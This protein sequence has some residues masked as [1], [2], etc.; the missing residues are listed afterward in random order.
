MNLHEA[1]LKASLVRFLGRKQMPRRFEGKAGP[2]DDEIAALAGV[3]ARNAPRGADRLAAWWPHFE[4]RLGEICGSMW[5]TEKEIKDAAKQ[6][7]QEAPTQGSASG[8]DLDLSPVAVTARRMQRND[9]VGDEWLW[10]RRAVELATSGLIDR[11]TVQRYRSGAF[12]AR[13]ALYGEE[14][15]LA[16]ETEAKD[17]HEAAK[18]VWRGRNDPPKQRGATVPDM[19]SPYD[20]ETFAA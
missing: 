13:K 5:P 17:R 4:S 15:A 16:W 2:M 7:S 6:A 3:L 9:P 19:A 8:D 10:G 12:L 20:P 14:A 11:E 18:A 1:D